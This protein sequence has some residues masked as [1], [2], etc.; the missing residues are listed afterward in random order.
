MRLE[1]PLA[2]IRKR[3]GDIA[4]CLMPQVGRKASVSCPLITIWNDAVFTQ[5]M[6]MLMKWL[7]NCI[8]SIIVYK[9]SHSTLSN[10]LLR[11]NFRA[12]AFYLPLFLLFIQWKASVP[13][14]MLSVMA[15]SERKAPCSSPITS[16]STFLILVTNTLDIIL[17]GILQR[18][19]G[20]KSLGESRL[21]T[22]GIN[23]ISVLF[24]FLMFMLPFQ[25]FCTILIICFPTQS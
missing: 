5:A 22:L 17:H 20:L 18:L 15:H 8:F 3:K 23:T 10:T 13:S 24:M 11:S 7:G 6:V 25:T 19:I 12:M 1:K 16:C 9:K 4:P 21:C 14:M 2:Q